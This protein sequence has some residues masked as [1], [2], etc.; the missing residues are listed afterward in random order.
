MNE[1]YVTL[2]GWVGTEVDLRDVGETQCAS[3]RVGSTPR[4]QRN[5]VWVDGDTSWF[6][7]NCWR[8]LARNVAD[9]ISSGD[10]VVGKV[11]HTTLP[12]PTVGQS[13]NITGVVCY[14]F[15]E[16]NIQPRFAQDIETITSIGEFSGATITVFPSSRRWLSV[17]SRRSL[18]RWCSPMEGSSRM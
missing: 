5:G 16:Y 14:G 10:A 12:N 15:G 6:T 8:A 1:S 13:M 18:S 11:M 9:S 2:T 3:F 4:R 17:A 7:V